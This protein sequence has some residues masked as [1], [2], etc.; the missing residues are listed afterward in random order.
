MKQAGASPILVMSMVIFPVYGIRA[1]C[2]PFMG[3][4]GD[5]LKDGCPDNMQILV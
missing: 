4:G 2:H 3:A 5:P 1:I